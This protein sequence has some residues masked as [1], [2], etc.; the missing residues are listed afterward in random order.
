[1]VREA[2][3]EFSSVF[4]MP[5]TMVDPRIVSCLGQTR[6]TKQCKL[7]GHFLECPGKS[8]RLPVSETRV[9]LGNKKWANA[10]PNVN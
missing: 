7:P 9:W 1:M 10:L 8:S 2:E 3:F 6:K 4:G 5:N